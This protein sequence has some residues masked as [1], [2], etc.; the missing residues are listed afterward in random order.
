MTPATATEDVSVAYQCSFVL[1]QAFASLATLVLSAVVITTRCHISLR[2]LGF[3]WRTV[4]AD[5]S[6]GAVAF[7]A[8]APPTYLL[9]LVLVQWFPSEH[10]I[11]RLMK[12]HPDPW[13]IAVSFFSAAIVA[14]VFEEYLFRGILQG[15]LQRYFW[16]GETVG[17][18]FWGR[19]VT[20]RTRRNDSGVTHEEL[21]PTQLE[22]GL[23]DRKR[24]D[25]EPQHEGWADAAEGSAA[26]MPQAEKDGGA[27]PAT[28]QQFDRRPPRGWL[29]FLPIV[30]SASIFA[31]L[32]VSHGPDWVPLFLLA[33]GLGYL[34]RQTHRLLP[35]ITVHFLLNSVSMAMFAMEVLRR[36]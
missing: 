2:E 3:D 15:W 29:G 21:C 8:L 35:S 9:Q 24:A 28:S 4:A 16:L 20:L 25:E 30:I 22:V 12:E 7:L 5:L 36:H 1:A 19:S 33:V 34:Y 13:L 26:R 17:D 14:P 23:D 32:H 11:V 18:W 6:L 31:L 10:P 27:D